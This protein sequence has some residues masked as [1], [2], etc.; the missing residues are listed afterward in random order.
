[1]SHLPDCC[2]VGV[3]MPDFGVGEEVVA[4]L[5]L[6]IGVAEHDGEVVAGA[7]EA[8]PPIA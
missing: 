3:G 5:R 2:V 8:P 4:V 6:V 1:M 7:L